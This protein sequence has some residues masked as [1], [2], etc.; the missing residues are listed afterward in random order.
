[1]NG[2]EVTKK[3]KEGERHEKRGGTD[4]IKRLMRGQ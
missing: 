1:M 3:S 2:S 4:K